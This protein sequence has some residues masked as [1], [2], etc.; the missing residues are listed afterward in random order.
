M[1]DSLSTRVSIFCHHPLPGARFC[2]LTD[3]TFVELETYGGS[4][5]SSDRLAQKNG[6]LSWSVGISDTVSNEHTEV[7][8]LKERFSAVDE[9]RDHI[10]AH[11]QKLI[12]TLTLLITH[13][14]K[15]HSRHSKA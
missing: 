13:F 9:V 12:M 2:T 11:K 15:R 10:G 5:H 1:Y 3:S 6:R 4:L 7:I 14:S 8:V